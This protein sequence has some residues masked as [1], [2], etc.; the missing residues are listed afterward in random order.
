[1]NVKL[2]TRLMLT[3]T[4]VPKGTVVADVGCDHAHTCIWLMQQGI[5]R[6]CIAMDVRTGPLKKA[7]ENLALYGYEQSVERRLSDGLDKL[8]P[9]EADVI[10]IAGMGGELTR[11]ILDRGLDKI[12]NAVLILEPHSHVWDVR[13]WLENHDFEIVQ[14]DMCR[15]DDKYYPAIKAVHA[16]NGNLSRL[17]LPELYFGPVLL[18]MRHPVLEEYLEIEYRKKQYMLEQISKSNTLEAETKRSEVREVFDTICKARE[19]ISG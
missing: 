13:M 1:M 5:A 17:T 4:M 11:D 7:G 19:I 6:K 18:K 8:L 14:E 15:E 9:N 2:S 10:I 3:A 12:G 16:K